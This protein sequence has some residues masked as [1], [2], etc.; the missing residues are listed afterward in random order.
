MTQLR[1]Q[2]KRGRDARDVL[3][4]IRSDG[5]RTW[6]PVHPFFPVHDL[7]HYAVECILGFRTAFYGLIAGGW[8]IPDFA[9][10]G[11]RYR[12]T[13]E[14]LW[15]E[16]IVGL[17]DRERAR[18]EQQTAEEFNA[19]LELGLTG[20]SLP[21]FRPLTEAD[22]SA[23]RRRRDDLASRWATVGPGDML[24]IEFPPDPEQPAPAP[25]S[26]NGELSAP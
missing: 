10:R 22:L 2:L 9:N 5:S 16:H 1:I 24:E 23:I 13:E 14:T 19:A 3:V 26:A 21:G 25:A 15:A 7:T 12:M 11:S 4:C 20:S 18:G 8:S 6:S 17:L